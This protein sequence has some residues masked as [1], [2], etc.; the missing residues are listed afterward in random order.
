MLVVI[1]FP[2]SRCTSTAII[3]EKFEAWLKEVFLRFR[4]ANL[5]LKVKKCELFQR[6]VSFLGHIV[7]KDGISADP[8]K[9][10]SVK[11]WSVPKNTTEVRSFFR[12]L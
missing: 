5:K 9:I 3:R 6:S 12:V 11:S 4:K 8:E 7:S 1:N 10:E 2:I